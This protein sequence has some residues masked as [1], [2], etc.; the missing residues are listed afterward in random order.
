MS[1]D[2]LMRYKDKIWLKTNL[3]IINWVNVIPYN[4]IMISVHNQSY[5]ILYHSWKIAV[6]AQEKICMITKFR[7]SKMHSSPS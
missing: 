2:L 3:L 4:Q 1:R 5:L 6:L 7:I